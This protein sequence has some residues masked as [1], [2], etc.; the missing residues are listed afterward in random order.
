MRAP[1]FGVALAKAN[2]KRTLLSALF[3]S[4][5]LLTI[6]APSSS[7]LTSQNISFTQPSAMTFQSSPAQTL[8][9]SATSSLRVTFATL[10]PSICTVT[11]GATATTPSR[12]TAVSGGVC[13]VRASQS[14]NRTYAPAAPVDQTFTISGLTLPVFSITSTSETVTVANPVVGYSINSTGGTIARYAISPATPTGIVFSTTTGLLSGS[15]T[16]AA[17]ARVYTITATNAAGK[18]LT[19]VTFTLT[20]SAKTAQTVTWAPETTIYITHSP[21][22]PST[23]ATSSGNGV[24]SYAKLTST[25]NC[26]VNAKTGALT[27]TTFGTCVVR[28][29]AA[30]TTAFNSGTTVVTFTITQTPQLITFIQPSNMLVLDSDQ[31]LYRSVTSSLPLTTIVNTPSVCSVSSSKVQ[32][33]APG[34]CSIT[35]SQPGSALYFAAPS[36]TRTF[37]IDFTLQD[38]STDGSIFTPDFDP[39]TGEYTVEVA[40]DVTTLDIT[41]TLYEGIGSLGVRALSDIDFTAMVS[42]TPFQVNLDPGENTFEILGTSQ[43]ETTNKTY[44]VHVFVQQEISFAQPNSMLV[45]DADQDLEAISTSNLEVA[46]SVETGSVCEI[47]DRKIH[48]LAPGTCTITATQDGDAH[49]TPAAEPI[50]Q[51]FLID[52]TL[53]DLSTDGSIFTPDFDPSTGEYTVEVASDV[54]T[55]DIT[56]TLY[57]GIGSLGVRALSDIDFTAMVSG[58][59][60]QVNLDPGE[61]TFEIL[62]TSQDET[63][64]K[65]YTVHVF[66]QQVITFAQPLDMSTGDPNQLLVATSTS[67]RFVTITSDTPS[68]C[69]VVQVLDPKEN[70]P[71][72]LI[73]YKVHADSIGTCT[74]RASLAADAHFAAAS[75]VVNSLD[76]STPPAPA[77]TL[78]ITGPGG[79]TVFYYNP[80]GFA[81]GPTLSETCNYLE[82][83]PA[84]WFSDGGDPDR[85]WSMPYE[86]L[87]AIPNDTF[88]AS[89]QVV[90]NGTVGQGL[91]NSNEIVTH[92]GS[93]TAAGIARAYNG[94][95]ETDWYLPNAIE[96]NQLC[97]FA[98]GANWASD[99]AKCAGGTVNSDLGLTGFM[100]W[101]S[102]E[103]TMGDSSNTNAIFNWLSNGWQSDDNKQNPRSVRPIRAIQGLPTT[104]DIPAI[105]GV[106]VP[107][108]GEVPVTTITETDQYTGTVTWSPADAT[109]LPATTY[110]ATITLS[111]KSGFWFKG[112]TGVPAN[113]FTVADTSTPATNAAK[114][115][116]ITAHFATTATTITTAAIAGVVA[117]VTGATPVTA[118]TETDEFTGTVSWSPDDDTFQSNTVYTAIITLTPKTG[119]TLVGVGADFF[120]VAG[121][122][123]DATN[124]SDSGV[125]TAP[126]AVT[127]TTIS[128]AAISGV[129]APVTGATPVTTITANAQYTGSIAWSPDDDTFQ[130]NTVYTATITLT[131]K[132]GYTLAGVDTDF[133][134]V[135]GTSTDATNSADAGVITAPFAATDTTISI[136][137]IAG[138]AVPVTGATPVTTITTNAQYTGT[139]TWNPSHATFH[140][141]TSYTATITL[142]PKDGYTLTGVGADFFTVAGTSTDA[143]NSAEAGVI[144][145]SF[146]ATDTTINISAIAGVVAPVTGATPV[147]AITESAQYTGTVTWNPTDSPFNTLTAYTAT[148]TLTPKD[149][150]TLTG[151]GADFFTV[152]G[153]STDATNSADS[154]VITAVF[155]ETKTTITISA[156]TGFTSPVTGETPDTTIDET[157]EFTGTVSWFPAD[158][159]FLSDT[160]YIATI[161][162]TPKSGY[163]FDGVTG[164]PAYFFTIA[165]QP[166]ASN[167]AKSGVIEVPC[168][169]TDATINIAAIA[170]VSA[171]VNGVTP[172]TTITA[173]AQY[174]GTVTWSPNDLTFQPN[175]SYTATIT[176]SPK[177]GFTLTGVSADF[178]TVAGTTT[179]AT[180]SADAGVITAEFPKRFDTLPTYALSTSPTEGSP[181]TA[182]ATGSWSPSSPTLHYQWKVSADGSTGWTNVATNSDSETYT[183]DANDAGN[184]LQVVVTA[185]ATGYTD[186]VVTSSSSEIVTAA[187]VI[188]T[189]GSTGPGGG[190]I[191]YV[192]PAGFDCGPTFSATGSPT[193]GKCNYLEAAPT[194]GDHAWTDTGFAPW[195]GNTNT[196]IGTTI[197]GIGAGYKNTNEII[198]QSGAGS[199]GAA[200]LADAY[201]GRNNTTDWY[202]PSKD[203]L[204]QLNAQKTSVGARPD[205]YWSSSEYSTSKAWRQQFFAT[206]TP[207]ADPKSAMNNNVLVRPIRAFSAPSFASSP[208]YTLSASPTEGSPVT[209]TA[210]GSWSPSSPTLHYQWKVS[211]DGSTGWTN[212]ATNSDSGTYTPDTSD[213]GNYL[214]VV[215]TASATGY[216]DEVVT[217]SSSEIVTAVIIPVCGIDGQRV[218]GGT[219]PCQVGDIG[220]GGGVIFYVAPTVFSAPGTTCDTACKYLEV[221]PID[222]SNPGVAT[223]DPAKEWA[224][225]ANINADVIDIANDNPEF[226]DALG[227]GLGYNNSD[228]IVAQGNDTTTA[229]GAA[230]AYAGGAKNDWYLPTTA[231]LNQLCKYVSGQAWISDATLCSGSGSATPLLGLR[232]SNY[233]TSSEKSAGGVWAQAF[234]DGH[235]NGDAP[236]SAPQ[237]VRP[238]RAFGPPQPSGA[239]V[240][241]AA[242]NLAGAL[243]APID[244]DNSTY[245]DFTYEAWVMPTTSNGSESFIDNEYLTPGGINF[246]N[247]PSTDFFFFHT[248]PYGRSSN[249]RTYGVLPVS[250][251]THIAVVRHNGVDTFYVN[252]TANGT[253]L[254]DNYSYMTTGIGI[255]GPFIVNEFGYDAFEGKIARVRVSKVARYLNTFTPLLTDPPLTSDSDTL[256]LLDPTNSTFTNGA[257]GGGAMTNNGSVTFTSIPVVSG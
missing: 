18:N 124:S 91:K 165:G 59:P 153:T 76:I 63:T 50:T 220:P 140:S 247:Y 94:G 215:V 4:V 110:T 208:T 147:T 224:L 196:I 57:E 58:T 236:K 38:L 51:S 70:P 139:L 39:S 203:E 41:A 164:V 2:L 199:T 117:P 19:A 253:P 68:V 213:V 87:A 82:V 158:A 151:V 97:K 119:Y 89:F 146:A 207:E 122:S 135:V 22:T 28:A 104:I 33:V 162:L 143:T 93:S 193:G 250:S 209:A 163:W 152:A 129:V 184:Y 79:G 83:A 179:D 95:G 156:I 231:E 121:T 125:V 234:D 72:T 248:P 106:D 134:T 257:P 30:A 174:T 23:P 226:N 131:P 25:S 52:F 43:D 249:L 159:T 107:V 171:P 20:V 246:L 166:A 14:G 13:T 170:G 123:T 202:L 192:D 27:Y 47:V 26:S 133:F 48:A 40:S 128:I 233:W 238:I 229:A 252:G 244:A 211:A 167:S 185:S 180:N 254:A 1:Y 21:K 105:E 78:G 90:Y 210:T 149:G 88:D 198:N 44:T 109:F 175:T 29:N 157:D 232:L 191:F 114:Q 127:D 67:S 80:A 195:S 130:S 145:A 81:C 126:F 144:T 77:L 31:K 255:G 45:L 108:A 10:T 183:P 17:A 219:G 228:L 64:N 186:E 86:N 62:G 55:L 66:V 217:S 116:V 11:N 8:V 172:A 60:F 212:V 35:L 111:A 201:V 37:L 168:L 150:Y 49:Y 69:S 46:L 92:Y 84:H 188:Y 71:T 103:S 53:Q 176:L 230:R 240:F 206:D 115:G 99:S 120:T 16:A 36:I 204:A 227:I 225:N 42:G 181:V 74:L 169:P 154:G 9:A 132:D 245:N 96:L 241:T 189:L 5:G 136:A 194:S 182:T 222:W 73:G 24:I 141:N 138:V 221:A 15:P 256:F 34:T 235:Q 155:P 239:M 7:A 218:S 177:T 242:G 142:T 216:T 85:L 200:S 214:E 6:F 161:T 61:N 75:D 112:V 113:F 100:Y 118:I 102:S 148:I 137:A 32:A 160:A 187:V 12:V 65:T 190:I 98:T 205:Y 101:S 56:A 54:T 223:G 173:N 237:Y 178:F 251:W 197:T 3:L 243:V